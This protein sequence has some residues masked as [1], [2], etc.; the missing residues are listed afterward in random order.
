MLAAHALD[1]DFIDAVREAAPWVR[2]IHAHD[3]FGRPDRGFG[4]ESDRWPY[5]EADMHMPPGWGA[6][7]LREF[8]GCLPDYDRDVVLEIKPG[9]FDYFA[10]ALTAMRSIV[11]ESE[12]VL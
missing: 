5:G 3:N 7:P 9:F 4:S 6:I 1:F 12:K 10:E 11:S 2:H 8:F